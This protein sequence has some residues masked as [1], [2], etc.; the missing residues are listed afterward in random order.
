MCSSDL[1]NFGNGIQTIALDLGNYGGTS[2]VT[3]YVGTSFS[4]NSLTQNGVPPG[5]ATGVTAQSDGSIVVNYSNGQNRTIAQVPITTFNAP[6]K[7]QS[8]NG[9]AFTATLASGTPSIQ[10]ANTNGAGNIVNNAVEASNVDIA[11]E[12]SQ[13]IVAQ[14]AYSANAKM[15]TAANQML[16]TTVDMKQ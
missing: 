6:D 11:A 8:Q 9:E 15:I 3:Q 2:G 4:L 16:Q 10:D 13:L 5:S 12:F 1:V 7:L 14:Q